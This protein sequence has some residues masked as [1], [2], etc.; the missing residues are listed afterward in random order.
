MQ[1]LKVTAQK[2]GTN[3]SRDWGKL[4][5][6]FPTRLL[7]ALAL[8]NEPTRVPDVRFS[9]FVFLLCYYAVP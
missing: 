1:H 6:V 3:F 8:P 4:K 2:L 7:T 5:I 9:S